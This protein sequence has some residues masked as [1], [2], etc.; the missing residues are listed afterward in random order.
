MF[1]FKHFDKIGQWVGDVEVPRYLAHDTSTASAY[2]AIDRY[3]L[4]HYTRPAKGYYDVI[5]ASSGTV[6]GSFQD[7]TGPID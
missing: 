2:A 7:V 5:H 3:G 4:G 1:K 6:V